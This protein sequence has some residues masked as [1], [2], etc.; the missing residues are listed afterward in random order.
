MVGP[1]PG[2]VAGLIA[3]LDA[4]RFADRE[5]ATV[6]LAAFGPLVGTELRAALAGNPSAEARERMTK[7]VDRLTADPEPPDLGPDRAV[8]VLEL[9]GIPAAASLLSE[10]AA[11]APHAMLTEAAKAALG[12][13]KR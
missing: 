2:G 12:R 7:L 6:A 4:N 5:A 13:M 9:I 3:R 10:W 8:R 11:G 1:K